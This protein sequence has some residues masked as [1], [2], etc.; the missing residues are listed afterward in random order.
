MTEVAGYRVLRTAARGT[1]CRLLVGHHEGDTVV[2]KIADADDPAFGL[3]AEALSRAAGEHV[4]R[5]LDAAADHERAVLVL[6]RLGGG[7]LGE[8][9]DRRGVLSAGEAVTILAPVA[10]AIDRMHPAGVAHARLSLDTICLRDDGAPTL[11]GFGGAETFAAGSPEVVLDDVAGVIADRE[12]LRGIAGLVLGRVAG[13][14]ADAARRLATSLDA[15]PPAD[16]AAAL[17]DLAAGEPLRLDGD[18]ESGTPW[19]IAPSGEVV[20]DEPG[21]EPALPAWL[22]AFVPD[23]FRDRVE[24]AGRR[25]LELWRGWSVGRRRAV[26]ALG[27]AAVAAGV[28]LIAVPVP[29]PG[30]PGDAA[31]IPVESIPAELQRPDLPDDVLEATVV[32]LDLRERCLRELSMLCLDAVDQPGSAALDEDRA[33]ISSVQAGGEIPAFAILP[34]DPVLVERLGDS[35]LVDLPEGSTPASLLLMST[36]AGWRIRDYV[37]AAV[38]TPSPAAPEG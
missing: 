20:P 5:L 24:E 22:V 37:P 35:A 6:E 26:L 31:P 19:V 4:V 12:A 23:P 32:L 15:R 3:E 25:L 10:I 16:L 17:F 30:P 13:T 9:L 21:P 27:S 38:T 36:D 34:G 18:E 1:R 33:L 8:L 28:A 7:T 14:R 29:V 2:L 11:V